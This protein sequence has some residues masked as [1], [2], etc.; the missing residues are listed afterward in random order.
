MSSSFFLGAIALLATLDGVDAHMIMANPVP[1]L[2]HTVSTSPISGAQFPCQQGVAGN[3]GTGPFAPVAA[4][5]N[6]NMSF[7]GSAVH[8]GGSCQV[9]LFKLGADNKVSDDP[10]D[11]KVIKTIIGGCPATA[12]G[13]VNTVGADADQRPN[14]AQCTSA[15][16]TECVKQYQVKIDS[17]LP[18]GNFVY[19]W[20][21]FNKIGNREMYMNCAPISITGG[22]NDETFY[23]GLPGIFVANLGGNT[24]TTTE[25]VLDIPNPGAE[26]EHST[27][28]GDAP[29]PAALGTCKAGSAQAPAP[30]GAAASVSSAP[31]SSASSAA[32][33][34]STS[35]QTLTT[36]AAA[37]SAASSS[38]LSVVPVA[39]SV[40]GPPPATPNV[41]APAAPAAVPAGKTSCPVNGAVVCVGATGF[42]ICDHGS[43]V[44]QALAP[45]TVCNAGVITKRGIRANRFWRW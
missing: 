33:P 24:C 16:Q 8:G 28:A 31:A 2:P 13:N 17:K 15:S 40:A 18:S 35:T 25:G 45:G 32:A 44:T 38:T 1:Y 11:W 30:A 37:S 21:W 9:S 43:Y 12:A 41:V 23:N 14:G 19:A 34:T 3:Y 39:S 5:Q 26:V 36:T 29:S 6:T 4:G 20:T 42:G 10:N 7:T 22:A 27:A